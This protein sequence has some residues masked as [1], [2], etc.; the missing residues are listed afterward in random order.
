MTHLSRLKLNPRHRVVRF[1][2]T[3]CYAMHRTVMRAFPTLNGAPPDGGVG[4]RDRLGVLYRIDTDRGGGVTL[5]VQSA[6]APQ[7][8]HLLPDYLL[9]TDGP[10][11]NPACKPVDHLLIAGLREG[12]ELLFR[13]RANPTRKVDTKSGPNGEH[14]NGRRFALLKEA[15]QL[16][17]LRRKGA[18]HG[19]ALLDAVIS[20]GMPDIRTIVSPDIPDVRAT[21]SDVTGQDTAGQRLTFGSV[22]FDGRLRVTDAAALRDALIN[23]IGSGKAYGFGLLSVAPARTL[24]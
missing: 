6:V 14:R 18:Q 16:D 5:L 19:F 10:D 24:P 3:D 2:L 23:G 13:L 8:S 21:A 11:E 17:W 12:G 7:W 20:P 1:D 15:E 9:P 22:L 4:A